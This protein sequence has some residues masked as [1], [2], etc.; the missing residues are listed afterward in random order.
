MKGPGFAPAG[1][2]ASL[3]SV[4]KRQEFPGTAVGASGRK[5]L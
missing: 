5:A 1:G 4:R 3:L 2:A